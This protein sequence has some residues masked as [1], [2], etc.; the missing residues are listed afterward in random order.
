MSG[1]G[2]LRVARTGLAAFGVVA[3]LAASACSAGGGSDDSDAVDAERTT[4]T[5]VEGVATTPTDPEGTGSTTTDPDAPPTTSVFGDTIDVA[6]APP[7]LFTNGTAV[8]LFEDL[9]EDPEARVGPLES[10]ESYLLSPDGTVAAVGRPGD[11]VRDAR[12]ELI[13]METGEALQTFEVDSDTLRVELWSPDSKAVTVSGEPGSVAY[14]VDGTT[15]ELV[16]GEVV[17]DVWTTGEAG[18]TVVE[19][20]GCRAEQVLG[21]D[22]APVAIAWTFGAERV[23]GIHD[24]DTGKIAAFEGIWSKAEAYNESCV[25]FQP[26]F[27]SVDGEYQYGVYGLEGDQVVALDSKPMR[28]CPISTADGSKAALAMEDGSVVVVDAATGASTQIARQGAPVGWSADGSTVVVIGNGTFLVAADGSGGN[29]A[30][31]DIGVLCSLGDTGTALVAVRNEQAGYTELAIYDVGQD[32]ATSLGR[33][34]LGQGCELS[35]DGAWALTGET[36]VDLEGLGATRLRRL[37]ADQRSI[38][39][40]KRFIDPAARTTRVVSGR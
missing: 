5:K 9:A 20:D 30:S 38:N 4:T 25:G 21:P 24:A 23:A 14:G 1:S 26:L 8:Y 10:N 37:D 7:I 39:G 35:E 2:M 33:F 29:E 19:C 12:V 32:S 28:G 36:L 16:Q 15:Q 13:S 27:V 22:D 17:A 3:V 11:A 31:I 18:T 34:D 6:G 40:E